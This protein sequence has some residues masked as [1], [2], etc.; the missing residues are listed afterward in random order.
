MRIVRAA[1]AVVA[2][3]LIALMFFAVSGRL[4]YPFE[5][6]W[7]EGAMVI[8]VTR[9]LSSEDIY[10]RPS[11]DFVPFGYPALYYYVCLPLAWIVGPGFTALRLISIVA[12]IV[13]MAATYAIVSRRSG[14]AAG[15]IAAGV[16]AGTYPLSD[17][18]FDLGR[19]DSLYVALLAS[20]YLAAT[21]AS[22]TTSWAVCGVLAG[23]AFLAKQ[24]AVLAIAPLG[25]YLLFTDRRAAVAFGGTFLAVAAGCFLAINV[26]TEGWYAYYVVELPRLRVGVSAGADR[27]L[28]F[29]T[30]DLLPVWPALAA[31]MAAVFLTREWRHAAMLTGLFVAAWISRLE[32]GAW[33]NTV[34]PAYFG[35]SVLLGLSLQRGLRWPTAW[36]TVAVVQL[37]LL[38]F[39]PRPF[40][41]TA[42][43]HA[44]GKALL[45]ELAALPPPVL[46]MS[47]SG[48]ASRA[49][50]REYAHAW[51]V[52]D[53]IWADRGETGLNLEREIQN[54]LRRQAFATILTDGEG[55]WFEADL[56]TY[57]QQMRSLEAPSPLSG[58]PR[59]PA[60]AL[61]KK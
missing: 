54:A 52:T 13:T 36:S 39:D 31:G 33:N 11:L 27:A 61:Q 15:I 60:L 10:V 14:A 50:L 21:R 6:E 4:F 37:T 40:R 29:W 49:G 58:A 20:V 46:V 48:W 3:L 5:L 23:A 55:S 8:H 19:V 38:V 18:W 45:A 22:S 41:P 35:A 51:A 9:L 59:R 34:M 57:Y 7:M 44:Q 26:A 25:V 24:P 16:Y 56:R 53:V 28:S 1:G 43:H 2:V 12:T 32:G 17:G 42:E 30:E 47:N